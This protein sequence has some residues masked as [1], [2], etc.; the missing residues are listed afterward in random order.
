LVEADGW[1]FDADE[2]RRRQQSGGVW[3]KTLDLGEGVTLK[4]VRIPPG[5]FVMGSSN[6]AGD[7]YPPARVC[8]DRDFWMSACE[9][10]NEQLRRFDPSHFSGYFMK[11]S[12]DVNGPG[13][14]MDEPKQP[15]VRVSWEKAVAFCG[16]LSHEAGLRFSLP[17]EAQWEYACRCGT[18]AEL[19]YGDVD[20]DFSRRANVADKAISQLYTVTGGVIVLQD[21]PA[22]TRFN[23]G[24]IATVPVGCYPPNAWWLHDMHGNAAEWTLSGYQAYPYRDDDGRNLPTS[25]GRKVVRGGS[26]YDRPKRCRSAFRLSY[27]A[28]QRVHN[29]GF[30]VVCDDP[31]ALAAR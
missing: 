27:P 18:S 23:D 17:T 24:G 4:L 2:A 5:E 9:I 25:D 14:T 31:A 20:A 19:S 10:T 15:A 16:W 30:R 8:I 26:Y 21:I 13:I 28:W 6:G 11:R 12:L 3:V 29:V 1:P 7:E 22:D